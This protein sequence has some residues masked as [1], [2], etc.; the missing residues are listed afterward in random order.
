MDSYLRN[1]AKRKKHC[2]II[3]IGDLNLNKVLWP[4]ST[5]S[6]KLQQLFL[7]TFSDLNFDQLVEKPTHVNGKILDVLLTNSPEIISN[8]DIRMKIKLV[9]L[10][11]LENNFC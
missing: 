11:I 3:L 1:L 10:I 5:T 6:C 4:S 9:N 2:K 8:I 7:D